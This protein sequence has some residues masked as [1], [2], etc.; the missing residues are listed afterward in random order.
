MESAD[1]RRSSRPAGYRARPFTPPVRER[2]PGRRQRRWLTASAAIVVLALTVAVVAFMAGSRSGT[3]MSDERRDVL[4]TAT[5]DAVEDL[6]TFAPTTQNRDRERVAAR[7]TGRLVAEYRSR[8]PDVVL[9][10]ARQLKVAMTAK[11]VG[12][13]VS[14][15]GHDDRGELRMLV[16]ID[17]RVSIPGRTVAGGETSSIARWAFMRNVGGHWLLSD[18]TTVGSVAGV[19]SAAG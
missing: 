19:G 4:Q 3:G 8:G 16:F 18:L 2:G 1:R 14:A 6:M 11:V 7:L 10:G 5:R 12:V 15:A 9:A 13:G 17:Q